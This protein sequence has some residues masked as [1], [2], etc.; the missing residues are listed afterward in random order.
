[1]AHYWNRG[2]SIQ[3]LKVLSMN[4]LRVVPM[5]LIGWHRIGCSEVMRVQNK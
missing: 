3:Y 5:M 4:Y 1:M 2:G